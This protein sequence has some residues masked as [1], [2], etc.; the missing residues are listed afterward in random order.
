MAEVMR[1]GHGEQPPANA[2]CVRVEQNLSRGITGPV[3]MMLVPPDFLS[4]IFYVVQPFG[5]AEWADAIEKAKAWADSNGIA[6]VYVTS[7]V[8]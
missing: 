6:K 8:P 3:D 1:L 5:E 7:R 2:Q 4:A